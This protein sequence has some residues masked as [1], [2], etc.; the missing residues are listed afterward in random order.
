MTTKVVAWLALFFSLA[1]TS[2]A[3]SHYII[4][5]TSQIKPSVLKQLRK[6]V[7]SAE[8]QGPPGRSIQGPPG[9]PGTSIQGSTGPRGAV[10]AQGPP[11]PQ[12]TSVAGPT[13]EQGYIGPEGPTGATGSEAPLPIIKEE[14]EKEISEIQLSGTSPYTIIWKGDTESPTTCELWE[15]IGLVRPL[16]SGEKK[17]VRLDAGNGLSEGTIQLIGM[18]AELDPS[19]ETYRDVGVACKP[20]VSEGNHLHFERIV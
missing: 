11:G 7:T 2:I 16:R 6:P 17:E 18:A 20:T 8:I 13:G 4:T 5:S 10:G 15:N 1:G 3:A 19:T 12:G 9:P 14:S